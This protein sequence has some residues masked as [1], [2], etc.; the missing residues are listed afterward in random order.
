MFM[1]NACF[2]NFIN[3]IAQYTR[4]LVKTSWRHLLSLSSEIV[5]QMSSRRRLQDEY[6]HLCHTSSGDFLDVLIKMNIFALVISQQG[7][8]KMSSRHL[9][10]TS[11]TR[12]QDVIKTSCKDVFK[13]SSI[14]R[15]INGSCQHIFKTSSRR[16][17][18]ES[19]KEN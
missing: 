12:F 9:A 16:I 2:Q 14:P 5:F 4:C 17:Q 11:S 15:K 18:H 8:L 7:V 19:L 1:P 10:K 13:I 3:A 6:I